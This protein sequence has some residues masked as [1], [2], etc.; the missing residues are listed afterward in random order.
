MKH[1]MLKKDE[2]I[3]LRKVKGRY[4]MPWGCENGLTVFC[5]SVKSR[6]LADVSIK[7]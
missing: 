2:K 3:I 6:V 5:T 1:S 7:N 4:F